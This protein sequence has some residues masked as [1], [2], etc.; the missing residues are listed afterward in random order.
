MY[1]ISL[2]TC[3]YHKNQLNVGKYTVQRSYMG[4]ISFVILGFPK[5]A[6]QSDA[7]KSPWRQ[8]RGSTVRFMSETIR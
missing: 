6:L 2:P 4:L 3:I 5:Q 8:N 7:V 1:G